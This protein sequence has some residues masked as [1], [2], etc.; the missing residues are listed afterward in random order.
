MQDSSSKRPDLSV[1]QTMVA[2]GLND[3]SHVVRDFKQF[4]GKSPGRYRIDYKQD[5]PCEVIVPAN[6]WKKR[7][8]TFHCISDLPDAY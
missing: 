8:I 3:L 2:S 1:K 4:F 7:P 6:E 5:T